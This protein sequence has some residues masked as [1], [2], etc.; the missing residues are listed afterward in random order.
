MIKL[1]YKCR[2]CGT[3]HLESIEDSSEVVQGRV[4]LTML[5]DMNHY[6]LWLFHYCDE[7]AVGIAD[8]V[9]FEESNL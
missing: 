9:G 1:R 2:N 3:I 8:L 4:I 6:L 7:A 5:G